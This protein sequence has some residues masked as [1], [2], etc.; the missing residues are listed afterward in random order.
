VRLSMDD[1]AGTVSSVGEWRIDI[2]KPQLSAHRICTNL[3]VR[4]VTTDRHRGTPPY[5]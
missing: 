3:G 2:K 5:M 4:T 1:L